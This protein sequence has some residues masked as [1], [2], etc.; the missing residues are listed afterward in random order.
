[1]LVQGNRELHEYCDETAVPI[2]G[3]W[4]LVVAKSDEQ[5]GVVCELDARV[6]AHGMCVKLLSE[7][8]IKDAEPHAGDRESPSLRRHLRRR[9]Q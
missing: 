6:Q 1:V 7:G 5:I 4:N 3:V 2:S 9:A 8:E